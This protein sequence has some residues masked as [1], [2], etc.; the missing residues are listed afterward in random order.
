L[1][2]TTLR[3]HISIKMDLLN[4]LTLSLFVCLVYYTTGQHSSLFTF[5]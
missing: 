3:S 5:R 4:Q 1:S 2:H